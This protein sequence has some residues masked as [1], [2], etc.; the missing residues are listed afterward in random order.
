MKLY[1]TVGC[2]LMTSALAIAFQPLAHAQ[3]ASQHA[4]QS[5]AAIERYAIVTGAG[6]GSLGDLDGD[7]DDDGSYFG[8]AVHRVGHGKKATIA[9]H[10]ICAMWGNTDFLGLALMGVEGQIT[11]ATT[12]HKG[13]ARAVTL[14]GVGTVDL[15]MGP[16]GFFTGVPFEVLLTEGGPGVGTLKLTVIGAFDGTP[17]DT[18]V[19]NG[20][21]DIP[22]ETITSGHIIIH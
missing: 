8:V 2:I 15:G 4:G 11:S 17:G 16:S 22:T 9:G 19:G 3:G 7:G 6:Q 1:R 5:N 18:I 12:G 21:F 14:T 13:R 20:N 10:F